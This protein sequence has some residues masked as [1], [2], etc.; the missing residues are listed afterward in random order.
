MTAR[1]I[2]KNAESA[3][4][5][6]TDLRAITRD[7]DKCRTVVALYLDDYTRTSWL[8]FGQAQ[9]SSERLAGQYRLEARMT[10]GVTDF[11]HDSA[12]ALRLPLIG[13][14]LD[15][16]FVR[17]HTTYLI[18]W[19]D[20]NAEEDFH[21][22]DPGYDPAKLQ[23]AYRCRDARCLRDNPDGHI[24]VPEGYYVPP[25]NPHLYKLVAGKR[26][27]IAIGPAW[28]ERSESH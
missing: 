16:S 13:V 12:Y 4:E 2:K 14:Q 15:G 1:A 20:P 11:E 8:R 7:T 6:E 9:L 21:V 28:P 24:I 18:G 27:E 3:F 25:S 5:T 26:V 17:Y 22:P 19:I 10:E 23:D